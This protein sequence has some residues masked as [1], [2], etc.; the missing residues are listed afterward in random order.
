MPGA[1]MIGRDGNVLKDERGKVKY[2]PVIEWADKEA[3]ER[4][5]ETLLAALVEKY[6]GALDDDGGRP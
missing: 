4:F 2:S 5:R 3:A 1:A 6:P